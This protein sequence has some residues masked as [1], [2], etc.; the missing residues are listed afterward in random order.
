[1]TFS[2]FYYLFFSLFIFVLSGCA[3]HAVNRMGSESVVYEEVHSFEISFN[4]KGEYLDIEE[5]NRIVTQFELQNAVFQLH[6]PRKYQKQIN[7]VYES[8]LSFKVDPARISL[9]SSEKK[10]VV[11]LT[12]LQ[13]KTI[14]NNCRP[15]TIT[16]AHFQSGCTVQRNITSQIVNPNKIVQ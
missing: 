13:W 8:L 4:S 15:L 10:D 14:L 6:Y 5:F 12:V 2:T 7:S 11:T 3:D 1:M 16:N 9:E